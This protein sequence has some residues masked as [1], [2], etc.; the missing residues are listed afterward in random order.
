MT[1]YRSALV[2]PILAWAAA[3][4][5]NGGHSSRPAV[6]AT[7]TPT[8]TASATPAPTPTAAAVL[9]FAAGGILASRSED[10]GAA[11]R[12]ALATNTTLWGVDFVD[13]ST[14]WVVGTR[15]IFRT[16]TG[17]QDAAAWE[18][19]SPN[20]IGKAPDL[21]DVAF[22][23]RDHGIAVG[24]GDATTTK[25]GASVLVTS[26]G[27]AEWRPVTVPMRAARDGLWLRHV[28]L[29]P[30]G[31][32]IAVGNSTTTTRPVT[33]RTR[34]SGETWSD[35]TA[36]VGFLIGANGNPLLT[37]CSFRES[38]DAWVTAAPSLLAVSRD[39]GDTWERVSLDSA[40]NVEPL[41][42]LFVDHEHGWVCG[43]D[44]A[45]QQ[46]VVFTTTDG[47]DSWQSQRLLPVDVDPEHLPFASFAALDAASV[48]LV[49]TDP[50]SPALE[51]NRPFSFTSGDG[52]RTWTPSTIPA[53]YTAFVD[54]VLV[55]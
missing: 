26:D 51:G 29:T 40:T 32:A 15:H 43:F 4:G 41:A 53:A 11:W 33:L 38:A 12:D 5:G 19:Q 39:G 17:G 31:Q 21:Y 10:G 8:L 6:V 22:R 18:D 2:V 20:I 30:Q 1:I 37:G 42:V 23:D 27:G 34:D 47:G 36:A 24:A 7:A 13:R 52:G 46:I 50:S 45:G 55:R 44:R 49:G 25:V 16:E 28:C 3:C 35:V 9:G 14:G 48:V 54:V